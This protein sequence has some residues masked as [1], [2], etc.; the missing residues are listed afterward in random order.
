VN[1]SRK[2]QTI[3]INNQQLPSNSQKNLDRKIKIRVDRKKKI[4]LNQNRAT[5]HNTNPNSDTNKSTS[6]GRAPLL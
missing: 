4:D 3:S 2:D 6:Q 5:N 1:T